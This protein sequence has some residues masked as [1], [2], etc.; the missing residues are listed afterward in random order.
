MNKTPAKIKRSVQKKHKRS[1]LDRINEAS[2]ESFPTSDPP[3][4]TLG[5]NLEVTDYLKQEKN[6]LTHMLATDHLKLKN[7]LLHLHVIITNI[8]TGK[9]LNY[10]IMKNLMSILPLFFDTIHCSKEESLYPALQRNGVH[11]SHYML[12]NLHREH[13]YGKQLLNELTQTVKANAQ[14]ETNKHL[15]KLLKDTYHL[16]TN[17]LTKEEEY[18]FPFIKK[19]ITTN[20]M[21]EYTKEFNLLEKKYQK[22]QA[23]LDKFCKE[24]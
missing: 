7:I 21:I 18:V 1:T 4:W 6:N 23:L 15:L 10:N 8:E 19:F 2:K 22:E 3:S 20:E 9:K 17:H 16:Y 11:P 24:S 14:F 13:E 12:E 5:T